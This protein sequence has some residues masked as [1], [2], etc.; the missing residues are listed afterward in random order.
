VQTA[1]SQLPS[2]TLNVD[3]LFSNG[4]V[5]TWRLGQGSVE[6]IK[7]LPSLQ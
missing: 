7:T 4:Q 6:A 5:E 2:K 3:L 1:I